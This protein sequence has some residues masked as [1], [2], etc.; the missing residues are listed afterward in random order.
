MAIVISLVALPST[1]NK[2]MW[3]TSRVRERERKRG[4]TITVHV[5]E[6][7]GLLELRNL[8]IGEL[9]RHDNHEASQSNEGERGA[10]RRSMN[11]G[12]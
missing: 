9:I 2:I 7:E 8:V 3:A 11:G 1:K 10:D 5:E 6:A 12:S 4:P